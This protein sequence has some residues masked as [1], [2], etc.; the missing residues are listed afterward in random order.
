MIPLR[1]VLASTVGRKIVMALSGMALVLFVMLHLAGN[2]QLLLPDP[3]AFNRYA[4]NFK[5]LGPLFYVAE[6]GLFGLIALHVILGG[7]LY[8]KSH[9]ARDAGYAIA[10]TK[11]GDS[12]WNAS[13]GW[14]LFW[15]GLLLVFIVVHVAQFRFEAFVPDG[16]DYRTTLDGAAVQDLHALVL[17]TFTSGWWVA[18]YVGAMLCL[19]IH[20]RH[21]LWSMFQSIGAMP[22]RYSAPAY[23]AAAAVAALLA[24]GFLILPLILYLRH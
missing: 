6:W 4:A 14:M 8:A 15:G 16:V 2:L 7:V 18:F 1:K 10:E 5:K 9:R 24:L 21:G 22:A 13:S 20:L 12:R 23:V 11:G 19:G 3:E 17:D